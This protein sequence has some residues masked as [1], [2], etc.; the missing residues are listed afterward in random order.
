MNGW[1][2]DI[3][4]VILLI[5]M[6]IQ[7]SSFGTIVPE[8]PCYVFYV[9]RHHGYWGLT[10][11]V[12]LLVLWFDITHTYKNTGNTQGLKD[13]LPYKYILTLPITYAQ[14]LGVLDWMNNSLSPKIYLTE[15][16]NVFAFHE[17][18]TCRSYI[19]V[20]WLDLITL[21]SSREAQSILLEMV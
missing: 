19:Y 18:L 20:C 10:F 16:L 7:M 1:S 21:S 11:N 8:G 14:Q 5:D 13:W 6:D 15:F 9:A 2:C 17:L 12:F 3:W 4:Y